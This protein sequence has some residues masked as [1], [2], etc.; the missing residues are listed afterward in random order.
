M[1]VLPSIPAEKVKKLNNMIELFVWNGKKPKIKLATLQ[2]AKT[3]GGLNLVDFSIKDKALKI[4]WIQ[5]Y[6]TDPLIEQLLYTNLK[7]QIKEQIWE[8]NLDPND[9][10]KIFPSGFW[11]DVLT[12][13]CEVHFQNDCDLCEITSQTIWFNSFIRI[14]NLPCFMRKPFEEGLV[15]IMQLFQPNGQMLPADILQQMFGLTVWQTNQII[16]A[17]P[18]QWKSKINEIEN[19]DT[20]SDKMLQEFL[21]CKKA[22]AFAYTKLNVSHVHLKN[23]YQ[24]WSKKFSV[25]NRLRSILPIIL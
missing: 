8:C 18:K 14:D 13:W 17:I 25:S 3:N 6:K 10:K 1:T 22:V 23:A 5:F 9:V 21:K 15:Y 7:L 24:K 4:S 19:R 20:N 2:S 16:S 11:R 12:A